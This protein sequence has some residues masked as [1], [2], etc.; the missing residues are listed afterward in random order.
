MLDTATKWDCTLFQSCPITPHYVI[1]TIFQAGSSKKFRSPK[2]LPL[3]NF[4][5]AED[6]LLVVSC[7][8]GIY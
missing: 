5:M 8:F 1:Y 3:L 2:K 6:R 4:I 7:G